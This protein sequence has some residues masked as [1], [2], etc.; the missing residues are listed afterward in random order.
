MFRRTW[1]TRRR[2]VVGVAVAVLL[3]VAIAW[4]GGSDEVRGGQLLDEAKAALRRTGAADRTDVCGMHTSLGG[5]RPTQ[6]ED[7]MWELPDGRTLFL[8]AA[9]DA[10]DEP[11]R[12]EHFKM[13]QGWYKCADA[14]ELPVAD[15]VRLRRSV[16]AFIPH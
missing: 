2:I 16:F 10:D 6:V 15:S 12:V 11:F 8:V 1:W 3:V 7:S 13:W 9:R 4:E 5:R 14:V